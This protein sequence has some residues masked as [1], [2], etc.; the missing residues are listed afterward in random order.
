VG[1]EEGVAVR[2][3]DLIL[4]NPGGRQTIYQ[5]LGEDF[6]AIEPPLWCR[7]IAGYCSDRGHSTDILDAEAL[8]MGPNAVAAEIARRKPGLV[9]M[10]V[11]GHQPSASTQ[12]MVSAGE[13]CRAVKA[14][15]PDQKIIILGG[16]VAAL[17]VRTMNEEAVDYACNSEGPVTVHELL[18][19]LVSCGPLDT[20]PG[21]VWR[22]GVD[23]KINPA[24]PL[25]DLSD[26]HGNTWARLPMKKYRAH[27]WQVMG[28]S[29]RQ[30]YASIYTSLGCPFKCSFCCINSPFG[31]AR[32]RMRAPLAVVAEVNQLYLDY[33]VKTF[34][35]VDEMFVLSPKHYL[36][37]CEGLAA[38]PYA[39]ELNIWAYA[40][41]DTVKA[42]NLKLLREAGIRWL[43]LGIESGSAHVRDGADKSFGT[44]DIIETV[45]AIQDAGI[46]VIGN[47]IFGL[48]DDTME[49]MRDTLDL[50][51]ALNCEFANFYSAQAYP[52]SPLHGMA[53]PEDLPK[54][55]SGYSQHS[56]DTT[57]LPT[58]TLTSAEVL[59]FRD[60]AFHEY[61]TSHRYLDMIYRK[62][63]LITVQNIQKMTAKRL[64]R[65]A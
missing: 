21:L 38:L 6:T 53:N 2:V 4:V 34:K 24:P 11:Y 20:V 39:D 12:Q 1:L 19:C 33:G 59:K 42:G 45:S 28:G 58:K 14:A 48:P 26:L 56:I 41:I 50:A 29:S 64:E 35:I 7:L 46:N 49:S 5:D 37:I 63:G 47:F 27:N 31:E 62:F 13:I 18:L 65:A 15:A 52:G 8:G 36:A 3:T 44:D 25:V 61:F 30:P 57:P 54:R 23:I 55:W 16:H 17:P 60:D 10:V 40:R 32:Y 9:A 22:D 51:V 43:A